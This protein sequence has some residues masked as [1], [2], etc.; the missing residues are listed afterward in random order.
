M[1][2]WQAASGTHQLEGQLEVVAQSSLAGWGRAA[3]HDRARV[4]LR[5]QYN[6]WQPEDRNLNRLTPSLRLI[7]VLP[8]GH[9]PR[10]AALPETATA[11]VPELPVLKFRVRVVLVVVVPCT[12][13]R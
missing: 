10:A 1:T 13:H 8:V 2:H 9:F 12:R 3:G 4:A 5:L 6:H 7:V 11:G